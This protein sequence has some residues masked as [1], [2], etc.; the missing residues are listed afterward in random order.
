MITRQPYRVVASTFGEGHRSPVGLGG[1][2]RYR[3]TEGW[4]PAAGVHGPAESRRAGNGSRAGN[5]G[6]QARTEGKAGRFRAF[7][8]LRARGVAVRDAGA[9]PA[10]NVQP[11][12]ARRYEAE[13]L[14]AKG[15]R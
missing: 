1:G 13:R 10:V 5:A 4:N 14:A 9:D 3:G 8:D 15:Q 12:T 6:A 2:Y 7:C 11:K